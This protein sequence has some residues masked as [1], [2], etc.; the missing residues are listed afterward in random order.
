[1][2]DLPNIFLSKLGKQAENLSVVPVAALA[3]LLFLGLI[4]GKVRRARKPRRASFSF[5]DLRCKPILTEHEKGFFPC[6]LEALPQYHVFPQVSLD[7][8]MPPAAGLSNGAAALRAIAS[9]R[10][11]PIL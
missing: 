3:G 8:V 5:S 6:L 7:A 10:N 2:Q 11:T 1:M 4:L 9:A